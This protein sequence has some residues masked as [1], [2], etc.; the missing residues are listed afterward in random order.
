MR[1]P[2]LLQLRALKHKMSPRHHNPHFPLSLAFLS[3][4]LL[5]LNPFLYTLL[6]LIDSLSFLCAPLGR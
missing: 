1:Y 5:S 3:S 6:V 2:L 4:S